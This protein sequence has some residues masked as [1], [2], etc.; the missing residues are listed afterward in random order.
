MSKYIKNFKFNLQRFAD[1]YGNINKTTDAGMAADQQEYYNAQLL[2][3][4][5]PDL[6]YL[7]FAKKVPFPKGNGK[8]AR[9][10]RLKPYAA[11][12]TPLTEGVTPAGK[13]AIWEDLTAPMEQ[14]GDYTTITDRV[15]TESLDPQVIELS[16][17]HGNQ[18]AL[19]LDTVTRDQVISDEEV[20]NVCFPPTSGG[21]AVFARD[22]LDETCNM[23][24]T[25]ISYIKTI[26]KKNGAKRF[27]SEYVAIIHPDIEHDV[28]THGKF[29]SIAEYA[30]P[31][32]IF[33]GEIGE[34]YGVR[35]VVSPN[36]KVWRDNTCPSYTEDEETKYLA[37][38]GCIFFGVDAYAAIEIT[39]EHSGMII[40]QVGAGG[41]EDPL[42]QRGSIG[43]KNDGFVA[44][45]LNG[46]HIVTAEVCS[47]DFSKITEA[48]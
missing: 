33:A 21:T 11:A 45:V 36:A 42:N 46:L 1:P 44:K 20:V 16:R 23:T 4:T 43:W 28:T 12:T 48:N 2:R 31:R 32:R 10:R 34:L 22:D 24:P 37:V 29:V 9:F 30:A 39:K 35:F 17:N 26:L 14:Y 3:Y 25:F 38:Y 18:Q 15:V 8:T 19:T 27:G 7:Q 5:T 40:K 41:S 47:K 13:K 6:Y